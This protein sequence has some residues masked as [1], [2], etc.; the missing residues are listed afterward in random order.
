MEIQSKLLGDQQI[1]PTTIITFPHGIPGFEN[2]TRFKFFHQEGSEIVFWLQAVDNAD[3]TFSVSNPLY[4][5]INYN[6]TLTDEEETLLQ[7]SNDDNLIILIIL[8]KDNEEDDTGKPVIKGSIK[9]P[10][11]INIEKRIGYQKVLTTVE[12]SI[13]LVEKSNEID[14]TEI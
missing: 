12:Q 4:F 9:S 7:I 10:L 1:D 2:Q 5:S 3:V 11:L 13:T 8:H 6:F 14:L